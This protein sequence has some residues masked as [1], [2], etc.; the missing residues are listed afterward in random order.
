MKQIV[1]FALFIILILS[2]KE[3]SNLVKLSGPIFGTSYSI[4]YTTKANENYQ[5]QIDTLFYVINKSMSN[6][7]KNSDISKV[8]RNESKLVD[9]HFVTVFNASKKIY[10]ETNGVFDPTIGKL[11]NAW[12]FGSDNNKTPLDSLRID[13]L[14]AYV[15]FDKL[16]IN[17]K[18]LVKKTPHSYVDFNAIAKGYGIDVISNF[19]DSK[20]INNYLVEIGGEIRAKGKHPMKKDYWRVG[21]QD[22]N[23]NGA[24]SYSKTVALNN[25]SMATSGTYRKFKID[26]N[27]QKYAHIINTKTGYPT[28]TNILSV[29]V[30]TNNCMFADGYATAFQAMGMEKT[31]RFLKKHREIKAYF[32]IENSKNKLETLA[33]NDFFE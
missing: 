5:K 2:C 27:G 7:Q 8:N 29:S 25:A 26:E 10:K 12:N 33:I 31:L 4:L 20:D 22:P 16:S 21:I 28:K 13:S 23:F 17:N 24:T 11:V 6:Y 9:A 19:L 32:I 18:Q 30:I 1:F 3:N 14:M 15:G